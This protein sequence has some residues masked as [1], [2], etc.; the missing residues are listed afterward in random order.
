MLGVSSL[1]PLTRAVPSPLLC[2]TRWFHTALNPRH[3]HTRLHAIHVVGKD[4]ERIAALTHDAHGTTAP[5]IQGQGVDEAAVEEGPDLIYANGRG[6]IHRRQIQ[7]LKITTWRGNREVHA[8]L[9]TIATT[10]SAE[11]AWQAYR[12]LSTLH[13]TSGPPLGESQ[14]QQ[15]KSRPGPIIPFAFSH[16]LARLL[17]SVQPR[18][19]TLFMR[20]LT[21]LA[22]IKKDGG[23]L[24]LWEWNALIDCAGKPGWRR[25]RPADYRAALD[26]Y[27][28]MVSQIR[29]KE[30]NAEDQP[31]VSETAIATP[32]IVT[33]TTLLH[34]AARTREPETL[35]HARTLFQESGIPPNRVAHLIM[36]HFFT[37]TGRLSGVRSTILRMRDQGFHLGLDGVNAC[38]TAFA[39]NARPDVASTI[40]R[41]L[42]HNVTPEISVGEHGIDAAIRYL[43]TVEGIIV[44]KDMIPDRVTYTMTIQTLAYHGDLM[45]ALQVFEDMLSTPD[46]EPFAPRNISS[47]G[48][49]APSYYPTTLPVFRALFLGFARHAILPGSRPSETFTSSGLSARLKSLHKPSESPWTFTN[50][51]SLFA[52]FL[53]LPPGTRPSD[54]TVYWI[55][56]AFSKT[57]GDN[58]DILMKVWEQLQSRFGRRWGGRI[59]LFRKKIHGELPSAQE[60][61]EEI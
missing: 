59:E 12:T 61:W 30:S 40:Y 21:V 55:L 2:S 51:Q 39:R 31:D 6:R 47:G 57:T 44:P 19:R 50:L 56:V 46:L 52:S 20:L 11:D 13:S 15:R 49:N 1:H 53:E 43:D 60:Q 8:A 10:Q 25:T 23:T 7:P 16:R 5:P 3:P 17:S 26:V 48:K 14:A 33:Y 24:Q 42:R 18:T 36:L 28:D 54:S 41:V 27:Q 37:H 4:K 45:Q 58:D 35:H 29:P 34:I 9:K 22:D 32:D 38:L